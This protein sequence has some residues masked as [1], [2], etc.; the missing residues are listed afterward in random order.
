MLFLLGLKSIQVG[1]GGSS[2]GLQ[3]FGWWTFGL[4]RV[5]VESGFTDSHGRQMSMDATNLSHT[6]LELSIKKGSLFRRKLTD[7]CSRRY[8]NWIQQ[9]R[10][11]GRANFT[12]AFIVQAATLS[13]KR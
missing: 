6:S 5:G 9:S 4:I 12:S 10:K 13:V 7:N 8:R 3:T 1:R 2:S 11:R